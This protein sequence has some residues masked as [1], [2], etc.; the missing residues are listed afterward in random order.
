MLF[1]C[2]WKFFVSYVHKKIPTTVFQKKNILQKRI[3]L[4]FDIQ[5][6]CASLSIISSN[7]YKNITNFFVRFYNLFWKKLESCI[8]K[9]HSKIVKKNQFFLMWINS[10]SQIFC[11]KFISIQTKKMADITMPCVYEFSRG[12]G[13][14][15]AEALG[16]WGFSNRVCNAGHELQRLKCLSAEI[17]SL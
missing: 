6:L 12:N 4:Y 3:K 8:D 9:L 1:I 7:I 11:A 13:T 2:V 10:L 15:V 16:N 14:G 17:D 5:V